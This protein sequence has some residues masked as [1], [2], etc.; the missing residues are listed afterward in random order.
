MHVTTNRSEVDQVSGRGDD[1]TQ[2]ERLDALLAELRKALEGETAH[3]WQGLD[4]AGLLE[5]M[6][7]AARSASHKRPDANPYKSGRFHDAAEYEADLFTGVVVEMTYSGELVRLIERHR[8]EL[9]EGKVSDLSKLLRRAATERALDSVR[10]RYGYGAHV[11]R[12]GELPAAPD[13]RVLIWAE[14]IEVALGAAR[15]EVS[16]GLVHDGTWSEAQQATWAWVRGAKVCKIYSMEEVSTRFGV[17]I[18]TLDQ[19]YP[20]L[21]RRL[22]LRMAALCTEQFHGPDLPRRFRTGCVDG[23]RGRALAGLR[24]A[25]WRGRMDAA[26]A[27]LLTAWMQAADPCTAELLEWVTGDATWTNETSGAVSAQDIY[28]RLGFGRNAGRAKG[29]QAREACDQL[30]RFYEELKT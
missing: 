25:R 14:A 3:V 11:D 16:H 24:L 1:R 8:A 15:L 19:R 28:D 26:Q 6:R 13:P 7:R 5:V 29:S 27:A 9:A 21:E 17:S 22:H 4:E 20:A 18:D 2:D 12:T 30:A 23:E 10:D